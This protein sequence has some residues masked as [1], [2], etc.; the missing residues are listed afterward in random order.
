MTAPFTAP[1]ELS[2]V[3]WAVQLAQ[4]LPAFDAVLTPALTPCLTACTALSLGEPFWPQADL[5]DVQHRLR[6]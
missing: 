3:R 1:A 5:L 4:D 6:C 2:L